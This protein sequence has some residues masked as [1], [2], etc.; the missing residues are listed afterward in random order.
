LAEPGGGG[1]AAALTLR[2][3]GKKGIIRYS[4]YPPY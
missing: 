3:D 1:L 2:G 4:R